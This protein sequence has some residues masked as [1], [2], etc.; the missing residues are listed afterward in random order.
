[1]KRIILTL[2]FLNFLALA[3]VQAQGLAGI[4]SERLHKQKVSM[5]VLGGWAAGNIAAGSILASQRKGEDKYFHLMNAGWNLVNL[6]LATAGYLSAASSGP[7]GLDLYT[8]IQEQQRI[9]K[10]FLFNAGLDVG[11]MM[12]GLYLMER[13]KQTENKPER[14]RGFGKSI[15]LQGAFLFVFDLGAFF[16]QAQGNEALQPLL[17]GLTFDG[18]SLG[19]VLRF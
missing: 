9:Q 18:Q 3:Y 13:S 4:N 8:T 10:I 1:M 12:G 14:L 6:G 16:W 7:S 15:L 19:M 2:T 11:Y 5:L 17:E